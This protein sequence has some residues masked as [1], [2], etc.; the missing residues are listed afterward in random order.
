MNTVEREKEGERGGRERGGGERGGR[1]G[2]RE[3]QSPSMSWF[4]NCYSKFS[5]ILGFSRPARSA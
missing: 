2:D 3:K 4:E 1:E 5:P